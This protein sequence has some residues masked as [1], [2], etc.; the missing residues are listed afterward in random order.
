MNVFIH[1]SI[2]KNVYTVQLVAEWMK[3]LYH[4]HLQPLHLNSASTRLLNEAFTPHLGFNDF[5]QYQ[6]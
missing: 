6:Q 1:H 5:V 2:M 4:T 3:Q